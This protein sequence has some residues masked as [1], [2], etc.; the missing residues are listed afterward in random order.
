MKKN[1]S[2]IVVSI[3]SFVAIITSSTIFGFVYL[4]P[5]RFWSRCPRHV[6]SDF[7][8]YRFM[9]LS[10]IAGNP[11]RFPLLIALI[12][13]VGGGLL[14]GVWMKCTTSSM[15]PSGMKEFT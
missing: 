11:A 3:S 14:S 15:V 9:L 8:K 5:F 13:V 7:G 10:V 2:L 4:V 12:S 1:P 6:S